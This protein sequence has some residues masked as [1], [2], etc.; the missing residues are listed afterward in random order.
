M[1]NGKGD[2]NRTKDHSTYRK[3][4]DLI[5]KKARKFPCK[6]KKS[7]ECDGLARIPAKDKESVRL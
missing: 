2:K 5:F 3:N 4:Y 1:S 6:P 7:L